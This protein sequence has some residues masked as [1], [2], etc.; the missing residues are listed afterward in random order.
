MINAE[1]KRILLAQYQAPFDP[2]SG[3][4]AEEL[5]KGCYEILQKDEEEG[6]SRRVIKADL[7][8]YV[9]RNARL[10]APGE[11]A[12]ADAIDHG[13]II[14]GEIRGDWMRRVGREELGEVCRLNAAAQ[15][16]R[17]YEA[18]SDFGHVAPDWERLLRLGIPGL[19]EELSRAYTEENAEFYDCSRKV[20]DAFSDYAVRLSETAER[21]GGEE[22]AE[23][24]KTLRALTQAPPKTLREAIQ[25][26]FLVYRVQE[27]VEGENC[28]SIGRLDQLLFPFLKKG[29]KG[30]EE[31]RRLLAQMLLKFCAVGN[32]NNIPITLAGVDREGKDAVNRMTELILEEYISLDIQ[33]PKLHIRVGEKTPDTVLKTVLTSIRDGK[34]SFV[35]LNDGVVIP[36]LQG[37]GEELS[38]A[39]NYLLI[40]C[41]EPAAAG[42]EIPCTCNG[43]IN[44]EK[45]V[46]AAMTNGR[47]LLT[48]EEV[49]IRTGEDFPDFESFY[50]AV[51]EQLRFFADRSVEKISLTERE[52]MRMNPSPF[53]SANIEECVKRGKDVYEGGA[54]YNNSSICLFALA[55]A[56]DSL[57]VIKKLVYEEKRLTLAALREI[58]Q[59]NWEGEEL[60][61]EECILRYP[62]YG[63]G[64]PLPDGFAKELSAFAS[65]CISGRP[66]G[67]GGVFRYGL[68]SV[69]WRMNFGAHTAAG[70]NGRKAGEPLSKNMS[71]S[72]GLDKNGVSA[73]MKS[74]AS[75]DYGKVCDGTVLDVMLHPSS[76]A[77]EA[78]M[79]AF[80]AL[81]KTYFK[82][83][84]MAV[85]FNVVSPEQLK[86]AQEH[87]EEYATLQIRLCGWN[88]YFVSLSRKEQDDFIAQCASLAT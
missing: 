5:K 46:E 70:A 12:F 29:E 42:K 69:D 55:D 52:Y 79:N 82:K 25:L 50:A 66:N 15:R 83:G 22:S 56:V 40:G 31:A 86:K 81:L 76:V 39:R 38:D 27:F 63:N 64:D 21:T 74:A 6:K 1:K 49:G 54:K 73:L 14:R 47:D 19:K 34:N 88:V 87:P 32:L 28:R 72:A 37:L 43:R 62:K 71:A 20:L 16:T 11:A 3:I 77:G 84:G 24:A 51:K 48:G 59:K 26:I 35:F 8:A 65:E 9:L 75:V 17:S 78:G 45:A 33:D 10:S 23:T 41:Y 18:G 44:A 60:L 30:E 7:L 53:L 13:N 2:E 4:S 58:L 85:Q 80:L 61:R 57:T 36:A 67:R 68:F